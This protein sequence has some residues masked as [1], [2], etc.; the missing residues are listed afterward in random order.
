MMPMA[1]RLRDAFDKANF[2]Y[3]DDEMESDIKIIESISAEEEEDIDID[4]PHINGE[5][6]KGKI[7][8]GFDS[9]KNKASDIKNK[10]ESYIN[11][12][13]SNPN[14][15]FEE[16]KKYKELLDLGIITEEEFQTKKNELLDL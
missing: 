10:A 7:K 15:P 5:D 6:I 14:D 4:E 12:Q 11:D 2:D 8:N 16:I 9:L 3:S 13:N 1:N